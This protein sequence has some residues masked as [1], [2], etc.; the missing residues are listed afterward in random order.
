MWRAPGKKDWPKVFWGLHLEGFAVL[1][2]G[3]DV[4]ISYFDVKKKMIQT[5]HRMSCPFFLM[6]IFVC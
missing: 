2:C 4:T 3:F 1:M 5:I 6:A